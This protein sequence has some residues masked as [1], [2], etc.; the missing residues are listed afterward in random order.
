M[1]DD[2]V[3][4]ARNCIVSP[5]GPIQSTSNATAA[6]NNNAQKLYTTKRHRLVTGPNTHS[7]SDNNLRGSQVFTAKINSS[8]PVSATSLL[9]QL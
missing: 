3:E 6:T 7:V 1:T 9:S 4:S 5:P 8:T 2:A